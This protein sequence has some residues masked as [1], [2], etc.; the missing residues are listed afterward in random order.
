MNLKVITLRNLMRRKGKAAFVIAGLVIGVSTVVGIISFVDAMTNDINDKL[1]KYGANILIVPKTENLALTY[2]GLSLGGVSFEMEEIREAELTQVGS[3]K[4]ARN[5]AA[6][7]PLVLGVIEV[8]DRRVLMAGVD[9]EAS[10]ILKPWWKVQGTF[11]EHDGVLLGAE[12]ARVLSLKTGDPVNIKGQQ[13]YVSGVLQPTGSQDDQLVF[14]RILTAQSIFNK[15]GSVSM[16]EVA[17]L[18]KDCPIEDMV[19]QISRAL[20]GA[21]VM[22][23]QQVVKGRMEAL[24]Q[25]KKFSYGIS[26][27]ILLIGSLVVLVTMMGSVRERTDEIGVFRAIGFRKSHIMKI[28]FIEASIVS[29]LAG[30]IGYFTG[31]GATKAALTIFSESHS[32]YVPFSF[33]LAAGAVITALIL[34]LISSAYPAFLAARLDPNEALRAL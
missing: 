13:F 31:F 26:G 9:F 4:N 22:A 7:G 5:I 24:S 28:V 16:A 33:E 27:V 11:P 12:A 15:N 14:S 23:I 2:G 10:E 6:L 8:R 29:G 1:E 25:F 30:V 21:K 17:A 3:I 34:G 18:C 20:P 19:S 32:G